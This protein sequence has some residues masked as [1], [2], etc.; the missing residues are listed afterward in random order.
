MDNIEQ[1]NAERKSID[2]VKLKLEEV[3]KTRISLEAIDDALKV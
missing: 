2:E 1:N 3:T